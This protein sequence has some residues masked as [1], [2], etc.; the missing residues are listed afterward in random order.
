MLQWNAPLPARLARGGACVGRQRSRVLTRH[1]GSTIAWQPAGPLVV[2]G[3]ESLLD[4]QPAKSRAVDEE[5]AGDFG[6]VFELDRF[7]PAVD[8]AQLHV[9]DL[10][11]GAL[12]A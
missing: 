6:A 10:G 8:A 5:I 11:V 7:D 12:H 3:L 2:A 9:D 1:G 4:E